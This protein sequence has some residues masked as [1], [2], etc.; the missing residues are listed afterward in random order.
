MS[1][2]LLLRALRGET[3]PRPPVWF[4]R[5]AGRYLPEYRA[6]RAAGGSF[7]DL[8]Y[9]PELAVEVTLQPIRRFGFDAAIL[10]CDILV[11][12]DALGQDVRFEENIGPLLSPCITDG[13]GL[14]LLARQ[15]RV[16]KLSPVFETMR[17]LRR[18]LPED[19][20]LIGFA[21][22]PWTVASYMVAGEGSKDQAA[23]RKW[24]YRDPKGFA[25][26]IDLLVATT[27]DYL[28]GQVQ[29]GAEVIQ[30]FDTWA[31]SLPETQF[32]RW[33]IEPMQRLVEQ[34][35]RRCPEIPFIGFPKG[36][37]PLYGEYIVATGVNAVSIDSGLPVEFARDLLQP[38]VTVQGNLDP[39]LLLCGGQ[40]MLDEAARIL[41]VLGK[42]PFIFNL[43][44]GIVPQ[45][46]PEHVRTLVQFVKQWRT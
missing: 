31:G 38:H 32:R 27:A 35:R 36:V 21:G 22:A 2:K 1:E 11:I 45:T 16:A 26:L 39:L 29:A 12:A 14:A 24:A 43:G 30:I 13:A 5:Q 20:T 6:M 34:V 23:A 3:L 15:S 46:P 41:D 25:E 18:A 19:V 8:C 40:A 44:H 7:L 4:M 37:G 42:G 28:V 33:C 17:A 9:T 10:F